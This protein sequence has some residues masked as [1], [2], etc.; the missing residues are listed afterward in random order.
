M[1]IQRRRRT[2]EPT[3][4]IIALLALVALIGLLTGILTR[5]LISH[6]APIAQITATSTTGAHTSIKTTPTDTATTPASNTAAPITVHFQLSVSVDPKTVSA[7]QT[8]TI[9]VNAFDPN[10]HAPIA[11][12]PCALRAPTDG[13]TPLFTTW[14]AGETTNT[15]G[16]ASWTL[17]AP[18]AP[19][20]IYEVEAF[21]K[22][23]SWGF[24]A[25][26]TVKLLAG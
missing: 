18:Q 4:L 13:S 10:T 15:N 9:T 7:G 20:G 25:D 16:A 22:T 1:S 14:P 17:T 26:S 6:R 8:M 21:A 23:T 3:G 11:G 19:A 12:L 5:A 2:S 24:K